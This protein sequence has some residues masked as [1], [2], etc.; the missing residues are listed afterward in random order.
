MGEKIT[1]KVQQFDTFYRFKPITNS[2]PLGFILVLAL[3]FFDKTL[4]LCD[5]TSTSKKQFNL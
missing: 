2:R 4:E 1:I 5:E 3:M